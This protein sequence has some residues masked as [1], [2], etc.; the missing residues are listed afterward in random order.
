MKQV[1]LFFP[2]LLLLAACESKKPEQQSVAGADTLAYTIKGDSVRSQLCVRPDSLCARAQFTYPVFEGNQVL[3]D[4]LL[5][6]SVAAS[7]YLDNPDA[8]AAQAKASPT[9]VVQDFVK[10]FDTFIA[11][12]RKRFPNEPVMGSA[13]ETDIRTQVLHQTPQCIAAAT[14]TYNYSGGAHPNTNLVYVNL[15]PKGHQLTLNELFKPG[16]EK[17]LAATAE[18]LFRTQ[19]GLKAGDPY[20]EKYFFENNAFALNDNFSIRPEGLLFRYNPYEIKAYAEGPT[21]LLI[22]YAELTSIINTDGVLKS[23]VK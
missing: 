14:L 23:F 6:H 20:G 12:Q 13:W 5:R 18:K 16:Y 1:S 3:T 15:T 11:D 22:P 17:T 19:E 9:Q 10:D 8:T 4:S 2:L 21:E 7:G